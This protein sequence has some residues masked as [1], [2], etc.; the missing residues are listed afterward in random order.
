[1]HTDVGR[2]HEGLAGLVIRRLDAR[3]LQPLPM[4]SLA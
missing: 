4:E 2:F 3:A 1:M